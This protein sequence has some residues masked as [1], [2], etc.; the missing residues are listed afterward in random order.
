MRTGEESTIR[1]D[2]V[3]NAAGAWAQ[4]VAALAGA[5]LPLYCDKGVLLVLNH[6]LS[7]R[8]INRCRKPSD[9]DIVVPAGP[10][11]ILGTSSLFVPSPE[12]LTASREEIEQLLRQGDE[13]IPGLAEARV[14]RVFCGVRPL[15]APADGAAQGS[16]TISR[17]FALFDH[18]AESGVRGFV[19]IIGGKLTTYRL[20]AA[21]VCDLVAKK[22][23]I[24]SVCKTGTTPLRPAVGQQMQRRV[25]QLL[26]Q[27]AAHKVMQRLGPAVAHVVEAIEAQ[28]ELAETACECEMVTRAELNYVLGSS[29]SAPALTI[30]DVGRRTR[31]GFGPCQGTFCGYR[32]MLAGFQTYRWSAGQAATELAAYLDERGKGQSFISQGRQVEQFD[33][34]RTLY[35]A[36]GPVCARPGESDGE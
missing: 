11:C 17:G 30:A 21:A 19:S 29:T 32:A 34:C 31:H 7:Q 6:R 20:M 33:L 2:I 12:G 25:L 10:V 3:V 26:P 22:L 27:A 36:N 4:S 9:G 13:L 8:V 23:G 5:E 14:L 18:E 24:H 16:R 15:H 35:G 28:P 1:C